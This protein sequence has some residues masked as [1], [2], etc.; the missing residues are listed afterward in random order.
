MIDSIDTVQTLGTEQVGPSTIA[1]S[2]FLEIVQA[3]AAEASDYT[4]RSL[5]RGSS[6]VEKLF[7]ATSF[8]RAL[9]IQSDY[10]GTS[11]AG[12]I[13]YLREMDELYTNLVKEAVK[14]FEE[15]LANFQR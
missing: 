12:L 10:A 14:P 11:Y 2:P 5:E 13:T 8:E 3:I 6:F 4:R 7:G 9:L 15:A 1:V